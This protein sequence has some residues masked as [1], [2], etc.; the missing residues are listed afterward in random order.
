MNNFKTHK[1]INFLPVVILCL[2]PLLVGATPIHT[3]QIFQ[4]P[5]I[6]QVIEKFGS[7]LLGSP[8][9]KFILTLG[10][11]VIVGMIGD[12]V[13]PMITGILTCQGTHVVIP[14]TTDSL[15]GYFDGCLPSDVNACINKPRMFRLSIDSQWELSK[16]AKYVLEQCLKQIKY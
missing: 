6:W 13:I 12:K 8:L 14:N 5:L 2:T 10:D 16:E 4:N 7:W 11:Q 9:A 3:G 15:Q 1:I